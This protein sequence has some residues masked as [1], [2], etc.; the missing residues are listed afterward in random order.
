[1]VQKVAV[2]IPS[3]N[4]ATLLPGC[5]DSLARQDM[6]V[7][8][9]VVDNGSTD[10][11]PELLRERRVEHVLLARNT[12]F[13]AAMNL[14]VARTEAAA[15]LA[16]NADTV[17]EPGAL[18]R[19]VASLSADPRCGGVQPRLLQ[20]EGDAPVDP[21]TARLYSAG[22]ALTAD[23]RAFEL[24]AGAGQAERTR[25]RREVF[26]VCGAACLLRREMFAELGGY[27]ESYF[28]FYEDVDLNVRGRIAGWSFAYEP[29]AVAW[30]VGNAS[31]RAG[32]ARPSAWN[33]R[34]VARNRIVT[35]VRFMP[36]RALPRIVV[37]EAGALARAAAQGRLRAT[38][39]GKLE[40]LARIPRALLHRRRLAGRGNLAE[41]R[42]WLGKGVAPRS[43]AADRLLCSSSVRPGDL[44]VPPFELASRVGSLENAED[45][46]AVY[47]AIGRGIKQDLMAGLP[48]GYS[49]RGK[50]ILDFGCG[51]GRTL[52]HFVAEDEGAE[53]WGCDI[54]APSIDWLR[55]NI[56]AVN[57]FANAE[58]PP[59]DQPDGTFDLIICVSVFTHLTR[60]WA[61]WLLEMHRLLKPDGL[62]LATL[63]GRGFSQ[64][65][66]QEDWDED[67]VGMMVLA[68]GQSWD[69]GGP[70]VFHS[71]WWVRAH[72]GRA[73]EIL[74]LNEAGFAVPDPDRGQGLVVLRRKDVQPSPDELRALSD[75]PREAP[76]LE[77]NV[78]RLMAELEWL[79]PQLDNR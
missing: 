74:S 22:Q 31:W 37:V 67:R 1:M 34:L 45:P 69:A 42:R 52:R 59:I 23:G 64:E 58:V 50:R 8:L 48:D 6:E 9:L 30:H 65:I 47:E 77:H 16:L 26:G 68:P 20:L 55:Q 32:A 54:D 2:V 53:L 25:G 72:W 13:A 19:L 51:A 3:W 14:G 57:A 49:L 10:G 62:L 61:E 5:L 43:G 71:P 38:L 7:E 21:E 44:P 73:F 28:S 12:G 27:D 11:T 56:P 18:T 79:R 78:D 46:N 75:D 76:A 41:P 33:A 4:S 60:H 17:L 29:T 15:I 35:Q 40:G 63:M 24:G 66:A 36:A 39:R 70:M